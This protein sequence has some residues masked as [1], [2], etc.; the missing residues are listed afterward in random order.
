M[1]KQAV[2]KKCKEMIYFHTKTALFQ[3]ITQSQKDERHV[4]LTERHHIYT[5]LIRPRASTAE[6]KEKNRHA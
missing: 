4:L 2:S 1:E 5:L 6:I 3:V